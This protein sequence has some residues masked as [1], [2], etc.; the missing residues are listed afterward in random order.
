M[1]AVLEI[2]L[3]ARDVGGGARSPLAGIPYHALESYL[4]RLIAAG[5]KVAICEQTSDPAAQKGIVDRAVVRLVTPGTVLEPGLLV[6]GQN[7]YLAAAV[8]DG[9]RA[10]I[11]YIDITTSEFVTQEL[12]ADRLRDELDAIAPAEVIL[13]AA[14]ERALGESETPG[15]V[16]RK[17]PEGR[18]DAERAAELLCRQF[19][20]ATLEPFGCESK[21]L[22]TLAAAA[23]LEFVRETQFGSLPQVTTLRTLSEAGFMVLDRRARRDLE[24]FEPL[25][26]REGAPTLLGTLD[27]TRSPLG[28]RLLRDRV[29]RPLMDLDGLVERQDGVAAWL[30]AAGPRAAA[31]DLLDRVPDMERLTNRVRAYS[32]TPR[33]L[34]ALARGLAQLPGLV[35]AAKSAQVE[36][37]ISLVEDARALIDAAI[38]DEPP[39]TAGGGDAIRPGF[40]AE[41]DELRT[42]SGEAQSYIA[43]LEATAREDTGIKSLKVGYNKVF[44][45]Y[46]EVSRSN[47][48]AVPEAWDRRQSLVGAERFI[49]PQ[50]K[51]YEA[52]VLNARD[53]ISEVER[54][55]FRRICGEVA[56]HAGRIMGAARA[57]AELDVLS[58]LAQAASDGGWVRPELNLGDTIDITGGRHPVVEAAL[59]PGRFVPNDIRLSSSSEQIAIITGPNMS[60]KSTYIRQAAVLVLMAQIG[61]FIPAER[62]RIG[63]VDRIFT[64]SGLADDISGGQST[65]MVEM[66]ETAAIL[67]QATGRS[68]IVLDEIGRGTSTYDGL[69]IARAVAEYIHNSPR[70]GCKTLFA[71]HYHE[72]TALADMLPRAVNYQVAVS[73]EDGEVVFLHRIVPGGADRSYGVHVGRLAGLPPAVVARAWDLLAELESNGHAVSS[74]AVSGPALQLPLMAGPTP[75][76]SALDGMDVANM[77]PLQAITELYRLQ[78]L[79][80]R[81]DDD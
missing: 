64:R 61:S 19:A 7:N 10:G 66:V 55:V 54:S 53:R 52:K 76:E 78:E 72:M 35:E 47:L 43:G 57:V 81:G 3:P 4:G 70:L 31:R 9:E 62:A 51:E 75:V 45:Y 67:H 8:I 27:Q 65:F 20:A 23:V 68:L 21:P 39:M 37:G 5:L 18:L 77:T 63:L 74:A 13:D 48:E 12:P 38:A 42:L 71:T 41:L 49:T 22:A 34:A 1:A 73:E 29:A 58:A 14:A 46:I 25:G 60:G 33:D 24:V 44:G 40:D 32:A 59:G 26:D 50:L 56:A 6:Q 2:A 79:A 80:G 36:P 17:M 69:S 15:Y 11:A 28:K 30:A 16:R